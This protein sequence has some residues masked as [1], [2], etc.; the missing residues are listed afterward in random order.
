MVNQGPVFAVWGDKMLIMTSKDYDRGFQLDGRCKCAV[1][2][3][4]ALTGAV[5]QRVPLDRVTYCPGI[6]NAA[7]DYQGLLVATKRKGVDTRA[8]R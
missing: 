8:K 3:G 1:P 6:G 4:H 7:P 2:H 5:G